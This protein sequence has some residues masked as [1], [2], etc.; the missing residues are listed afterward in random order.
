[1]HIITECFSDNLI[2]SN[3]SS[4]IRV[5]DFWDLGREVKFKHEYDLKLLPYYMSTQ[6]IM[7]ERDDPS[8]FV[9][10]PEVNELFRELIK[11]L[12]IGHKEAD[13]MVY[14]IADRFKLKYS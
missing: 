10:Y 8:S 13:K 14:Y 12:N 6:E 2:E 9:Q 11:K 4:E 1:M 5:H 7:L 3:F